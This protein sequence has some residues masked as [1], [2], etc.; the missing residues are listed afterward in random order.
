MISKEVLQKSMDAYKNSTGIDVYAINPVGD[1]LYQTSYN[2]E[3]CR[4][5]KKL[6]G[7]NYC[8]KLQIES[9]YRAES[10][11]ESYI[12]SC[13]GGLVH[14][15]APVVINKVMVAILV[16]GPVLMI[17][18]DDIMLDDMAKKYGLNSQQ[19]DLLK[20]FLKSIPVFIPER[21]RYLSELLLMVSEHISSEE[22]FQLKAK[23]EFYESQARI[24]EEIQEIKYENTFFYYPFE[25]ERQLVRLVKSGEKIAAKALLNELLGHIFFKSGGNFEYMKARALEL[26]VIL[27][28]AAVEGG[29]DLE[30]IFDLNLK[31]FQ[32]VGAISDVDELCYWLVKVLDKFTESIYNIGQSKNTIIYKAI[33]YIKKN[34]KK[35]LTLEE[36]ARYVYLSPNYFSKLF[37]EEVGMSYTD[38]LNKLRVEESKKYLMRLDLNILDVALMVGFQD[39][40]YFTRVFKKYEGISPGQF[41]KMS[42]GNI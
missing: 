32:D 1:V 5:F 29:A 34:Y 42:W 27:S 4:Y 24:A 20:Q 6:V 22:M 17:Q 9:G 11:G 13:F 14:W 35:G 16:A 23:R 38:Y 39:Q 10:F 21:I 26:V 36:V 19:L 25:K 12:F 7:D 3:F 31:Y 2:Y 28:R 15:S 37:K 41:R 40:S 33:D 30:M 8:R 18:P